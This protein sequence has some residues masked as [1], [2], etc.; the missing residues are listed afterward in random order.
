MFKIYYGDGTVYDDQAH[1]ELAPKR[2]IQAILQSNDD[3][4]GYHVVQRGEYYL[5]RDDW[6]GMWQ[7]ADYTGFILYLLDPGY[8]IVLLGETVPND[9]YA[10]I[11]KIALAERKRLNSE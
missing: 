3:K 2:G 1:P 8:K 6:G 10:R 5:W 9:D 7:A 4:P 11:T